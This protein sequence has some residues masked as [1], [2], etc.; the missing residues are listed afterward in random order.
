MV[1]LIICSRHSTCVSFVGR[2]I[3]LRSLVSGL[4]A[5]TVVSVFCAYEKYL[6]AIDLTLH[7]G[8]I[9]TWFASYFLV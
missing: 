3:L 8:T 5:W 4:N 7:V 9:P 1:I 6:G 2:Q